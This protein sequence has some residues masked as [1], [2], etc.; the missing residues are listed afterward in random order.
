M[1]SNEHLICDIKS[2]VLRP[3]NTDDSKIIFEFE[4]KK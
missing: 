3:S 1:K 4:Y 2:Y